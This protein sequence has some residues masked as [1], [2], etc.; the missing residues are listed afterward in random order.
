MTVYRKIPEFTVFFK[1]NRRAVLT[2]RREKQ[3]TFSEEK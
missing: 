2:K 3:K 1:F